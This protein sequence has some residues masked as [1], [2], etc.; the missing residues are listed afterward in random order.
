M[1][2]SIIILRTRNDDL[3]GWLY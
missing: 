1:K 2:S 3:S